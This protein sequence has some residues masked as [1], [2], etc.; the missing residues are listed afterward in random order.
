VATITPLPNTT[1][2]SSSASLSLA[3]GHGRVLAPARPAAVLEA[4]TGVLL[5]VPRGL[6]HAVQRLSG[7]PP[8]NDGVVADLW[9]EKLLS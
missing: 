2:F 8:F 7:G 6:H 9:F 3:T 5:G 4:V 1:R